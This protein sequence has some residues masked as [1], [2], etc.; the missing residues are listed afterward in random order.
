MA[1]TTHLAPH[2]A[3][4]AVALASGRCAHTAAH[5]RPRAT[6]D[7]R[8]GAACATVEPTQLATA[9]QV[10][11]DACPDHA[12]RSCH[13]S[14]DAMQAYGAPQPPRWACVCN[15]C[16]VDA[17]CNQAP[18]GRCIEKQLDPCGQ[19]SRACVYPGDPCH[20]DPRRCQL[21]GCPIP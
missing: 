8:R 17:H 7:A 1:R 2:V 6:S 3:L 11:S 10:C 18:E 15:E 21:R 19:G 20:A 5:E 13:W 14:I 16:L 4:L 12:G 9:E